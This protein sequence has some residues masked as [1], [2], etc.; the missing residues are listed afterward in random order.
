MNVARSWIWPAVNLKNT[1]LVDGVTASDS[2][3]G[4]KGSRRSKLHS[5]P[6]RDIN[7]S[8]IPSRHEISRANQPLRICQEVHFRIQGRAA[9]DHS[10]TIVGLQ[11]RSTAPTY[12]VR[13]GSSVLEK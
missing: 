11:G 8:D 12:R 2:H 6:R 10:M 13:N 1:L 7:R 3:V 4:G 9:A 5:D